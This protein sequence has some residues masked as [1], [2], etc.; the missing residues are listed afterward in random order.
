MNEARRRKVD[1]ILDAWRTDAF[2]WYGRGF[3]VQTIEQIYD[4]F[5]ELVERWAEPALADSLTGISV[6]QRLGTF[7]EP[8]C[9]VLLNRHPQ[10]GFKLWE[11]LHRG[12]NDGIVFDVCHLAFAAD[13]NAESIH[14]REILL[15]EA[16]NDESL[17]RIT[18]AC[19]AFNRRAWLHERIEALIAA[20][21]FWKRIK[22][23]TMAS[24]SEVTP[25]RFDELVSG[26][27]VVNSWADDSLQLLR[28]R[29]RKNWLARHWYSV[30]LAAEDND[31]AWGA[32]EIALS[33]ADE[34][35]L[36]WQTEVEN[37]CHDRELAARRIRF[38][39]LRWSG[40]R[41]VP[42]EISRERDRKEQLFGR[43]IQ[44]GEIAPFM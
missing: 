24:F 19:E 28:Q 33:L 21:R 41:D 42:A 18:F 25:E 44:K 12:E 2:Q 32:L 29:V 22:G 5:P 1:L 8:I 11:S 31:A 17:A 38:L 37:A 15:D 35:L 34:R 14:A 9:S 23:L 4:R 16:W 36:N 40:Q 10:L 20:G 13:D 3:S 26:A 27:M 43:K 6:R 30:F 39:R 7:L